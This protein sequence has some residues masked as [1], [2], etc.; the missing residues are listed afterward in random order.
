MK[1]LKGLAL[2][3]LGLLL[4]L[5][6]AV[7]GLAFS[8]NSTVLNPNFITTEIKELDIAALVKQFTSEP[9]PTSEEGLP[10]EL[11]TAFTNTVTELEPLLK[12]RVNATIDSIYD[13][14]LGRSPNLDL[15][16]R[17]R[18]TLLKKDFFIAVV[19]KVDITPFARE[20]LKK[21]LTTADVPP[22]IK[23]YLDQSLDKIVTELKLWI[24]EQIEI[25]ADP[26]L[27]YLVGQRESFNIVISLDPVKTKLRNTIREAVLKSP[28]PELAAAPPAMIESL[29]NQFYEDF[30]ASIPATFKLDE[31][32]L[33]TDVKTRIAERLANAE[34]RLVQAREIISIF[35]LAYKLL[36]VLILL[37]IAGII[38]IH[39]Q[40]K[41]ASR[42][43]GII[44]LSYGVFEYAGVLIGRYFAKTQL[45]LAEIPPSLQ[46]WMIQF[47]DRLL[48][49][50]GTFSLV[51]LIAGVVLLIVSFVYPRRQTQT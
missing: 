4:S 51:L 25:A 15:A 48:S 43:L 5:S 32:L 12:E 6:L 11:V 46:T 28:P 50:L 22:E 2:S 20:F 13:Y 38:L 31:S 1:F 8:L 27:D 36:I 45:P 42:N 9:T 17:L 49:P 35:Q 39:H 29:F 3:L 23:K 21:Q 47:I 19:D 10:K 16:M 40:V 7:F 33:G 41:G 30:S 14:L 24:K 44:F 26:V 34:E 18:N 37:S